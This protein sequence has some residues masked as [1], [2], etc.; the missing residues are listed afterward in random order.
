MGSE[1]YPPAGRGNSTGHSRVQR[2]RM[3]PVCSTVATVYQYGEAGQ[4]A[5]RAA[6]I[7]TSTGTLCYSQGAPV[8]SFTHGDE[9]RLRRTAI[10]LILILGEEA[11][12]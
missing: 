2:F 5:S 6:E 12:V 7:V 11:R 8:S 9:Y 10:G 4:D 3:R 1:A